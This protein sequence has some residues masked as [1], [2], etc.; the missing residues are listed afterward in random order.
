MLRRERRKK[1][2]MFWKFG[3]DFYV[4]NKKKEEKEGGRRLSRLI[5]PRLET[6]PPQ[7]SKSRSQFAF[8]SLSE[9]ASYFFVALLL[10]FRSTSISSSAASCTSASDAA[11]LSP[12]RALFLVPVAGAFL[13]FGGALDLLSPFF[14]GAFFSLFASS[15]A[16]F[17]PLSFVSLSLS[18]D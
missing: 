6:K 17:S 3:V 10:V 15:S 8:F 4:E 13:F 16:S 12:I 5:R 2:F 1:R 11:R 7:F 9:F 14:L 18:E